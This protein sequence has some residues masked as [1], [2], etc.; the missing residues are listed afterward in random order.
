METKE[1]LLHPTR[2]YGY[3]DDLVE[4]EG[5]NY[6]RD[7]IDC[8]DQ[9][10]RLWFADGTRI[11]VHYGKPNLAIWMIVVEQRGS[12]SQ[13]LTKCFDEDAEVYSDVFEICAEV[14]RHEVFQ[15]DAT[16]GMCCD[17]AKGGPCCSWEEN[18]TCPSREE[19]GRCW[20]PGEKGT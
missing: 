15:S 1:E 19:N 20:L 11:R 6:E 9:D 13:T 2:I 4:I 17:C 14:E 3:S 8:Y 18:K 12:A 7:E 16:E 5:G 10:V